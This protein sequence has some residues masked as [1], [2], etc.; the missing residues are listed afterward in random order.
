LISAESALED[1]GVVST[2]EGDLE[3]ASTK[4]KR[5]TLR[6]QEGRQPIALTKLMQDDI[7]A[8]VGSLGRL[9]DKT[10]K[11]GR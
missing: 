4:K 2:E 3:L 1:Y 8:T 7:T 5:A 9:V 10:T 11:E 6:N